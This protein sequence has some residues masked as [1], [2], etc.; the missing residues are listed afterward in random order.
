MINDTEKS[1]TTIPSHEVTIFA[2]PIFHVGNF[3]VTN[4][5]LTSFLAVLVI[6]A[7]CLALRFRLK[8]IPGKIQH[9]FEM[10]FLGALKL[11]EPCLHPKSPFL[12]QMRCCVA[13]C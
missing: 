3:P 4:S 9:I 11:C 1:L 7:F 5:L 13:P 12:P 10:L 6:A 8:K 2:E